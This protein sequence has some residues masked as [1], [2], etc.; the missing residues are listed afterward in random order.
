[1]KLLGLVGAGD[2]INFNVDEQ[3]EAI[4]K[5]TKTPTAST[6]LY[7]HAVCLRNRVKSKRE[8]VVRAH[9]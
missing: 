8:N 1:M 2:I 7:V 6:S 4:F 5:I 9:C 3:I